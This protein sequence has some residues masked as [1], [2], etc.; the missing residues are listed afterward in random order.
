MN[1]IVRVSFGQPPCIVERITTRARQINALPEIVRQQPAKY[2]GVINLSER[3]WT[4]SQDTGWLRSSR[5]DV[6]D[7][8]PLAITDALIVQDIEDA[9]K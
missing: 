5:P 3:G 9:N 6:L 8:L 1:N 4:I 2:G 7:G